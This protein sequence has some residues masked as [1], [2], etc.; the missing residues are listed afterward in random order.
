M[1]S[2][3]GYE[4]SPSDQ[5]VNEPGNKIHMESELRCSRIRPSFLLPMQLRTK[6]QSGENLWYCIWCFRHGGQRCINDGKAAQQS[7]A[8]F[9]ERHEFPKK[10]NLFCSYNS[11]RSMTA[12]FPKQGTKFVFQQ[13][14]QLSERSLSRMPFLQVDVCGPSQGLAAASNLLP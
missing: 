13:T 4:T 11:C 2:E 10:R 14:Q 12:V 8:M 9:R 7:L 1:L 5:F 6:C 3:T